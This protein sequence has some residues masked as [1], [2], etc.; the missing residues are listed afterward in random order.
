MD[1]VVENRVWLAFS[2]CPSRAGR[3]IYVGRAAIMSGYKILELVMQASH[4]VYIC[5]YQRNL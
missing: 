5:T 2:P 4:L 1:G 3:W